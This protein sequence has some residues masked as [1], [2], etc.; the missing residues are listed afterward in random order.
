MQIDQGTASRRLSLFF[1]VLAMVG[2]ISGLLG[3]LLNLPA[4]TD[5]LD[6]GIYMMPNTSLG[7][8]I[9]GLALRLMIQGKKGAVIILAL[10]V[11]LLGGAT[12]FQHVFGQDLHIDHLLITTEWGNHVTLSPGRMGLPASLMLLLFGLS[13]LVSIG[14][15]RSRQLSA[16]GA[17]FCLLICSLSLIGYL[18]GEVH[19][20]EVPEWTAIS[21]NTAIL[22]TFLALGLIC[23]LPD[24]QPMRILAEQSAAGA[25]V[26]RAVPVLLI[27]PVLIG[28]LRILSLDMALFEPAFGITLRTIVEL[29]L[30]MAV[31]AWMANAVSAH[32]R[33][34]RS[35][36]DALRLSEERYKTFIRNSSEGIWRCEVRV[37]IPVTLS[38]EEQI[39]LFYTNGYMA[40]ANDAMARM[41]GLDRADELHGASLGDVLPRTPENE[42]YL[43][44]FITSGYDLQNGESEERDKAGKALYFN[45][46]LV[47]FVENGHLVRAWGTQQ[48]ITAQ[49]IANEALL[50]SDRRKDEFLATLAHE[51][52]NP[53]SPLVS[54]MDF[55]TAQPI[56][57]GMEESVMIKGMMRRQLDHMVRLIDDLMDISRINRGKIG[58][59]MQ[60][61]DVKQALAS[62]MESCD[63]LLDRKGHRVELELPQEP[64]WVNGDPVRLAQ[65]F[66]NVLNNAAKYTEKNG[67]IKVRAEEDAGS[68]VITIADNGI[69]LEHIHLESIFEMFG[70]VDRS[71]R[72]SQSGLGI[73]LALVKHLVEDHGGSIEAHSE[74]LGK[75]TT[76]SIR[77]PLAKVGE[78]VLQKA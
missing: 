76:M 65:V 41:Y 49:K 64:L 12:L 61:V 1:S 2:G 62:A 11:S 54:G 78:P 28:W 69:G 36:E 21:I 4:L 55:L 77:L 40:E 33:S 44:A 63:P 66:Q 46:N 48:D 53:L 43:N 24:V 5:W 52:R 30:L 14:D 13:L 38:P 37:P 59:R 31:V 34:L 26:R 7:V 6:V 60:R 67:T 20:Y 3:W 51:L 70:Q 22:C 73:G 71:T 8:L 29:V 68:V 9:S 10:A 45:N 25:L 58:L 50:E 27:M 19:F 32:E 57:E 17:I 39:D 15:V 23:A 74:G 16:Y 42:A 35:S 56:D 72:R 18:Y 47:G 75:G